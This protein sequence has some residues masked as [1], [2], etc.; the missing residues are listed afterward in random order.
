MNK[1]VLLLV[2]LYKDSG[3]ALESP[4]S[5]HQ[6]CSSSLESFI[7]LADILLKVQPCKRDF[8]SLVPPSYSSISACPHYCPHGFAGR[9]VGL[10]LP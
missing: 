10:R 3:T 4:H 2:R 6:S 9:A 8:F 7:L 1:T 5:R